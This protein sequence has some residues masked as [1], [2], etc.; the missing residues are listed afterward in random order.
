MIGRTGDIKLVADFRNNIVQYTPNS[1]SARKA[2]QEDPRVDAWITWIDWARSNPDVGDVVA[3]EE[4]LVVYR[5]V[6]IV[7]NKNPSQDA[8]RFA[9]YLKGEKSKQIFQQLG[10]SDKF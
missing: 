6:N 7:L 8:V 3:I 2:F 1:G 10:W 4:Q 9:E 5:D